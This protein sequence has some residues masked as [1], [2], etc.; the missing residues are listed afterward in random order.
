MKLSFIKKIDQEI[1]HYADDVQVI[2]SKFNRINMKNQ[3]G[4]KSIKLSLSF[5]KQLLGKFRLTRRF[6]RL[7]KMCVIPTTT[8]YV[9]FWQGGVYHL[10][11]DFFTLRHIMTMTGCRNPLHNAVANVD[12]SE[13]FFGEY[14]R[15]HPEG[16][17]I[18]RSL[19][20]GISWEKV[21]QISC[22]KIRHIHS[23]NWDPYERKIWVFTG[24]FEGQSHVICADRDFR[25]VEWIGNGSQ[26]Y[27][28]INPLFENDSIHW[29]M[30]S[31]LK[32]VHHVRLDRQTRQ[33]E[34]KQTFPG[35]VWYSKKLNDGYYL[36]A[37]AQEVGPSHQDECLHF[38][39]SKDLEQ[40]EDIAQF[41][42]DH[43]PKGLFKF[44]VIGFADGK[45]N[46][47]NFYLFFEAVKGYDGKSCLCQLED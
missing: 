22:D 29:I 21:Y 5:V 8:G 25:E 33:I 20:G 30:D 12:G 31:P 4:E 11:F 6:L 34:I 7:D 32:E 35:P 16:K 17:S 9:V 13:L 39:V 10:N 27:R 47:D 2:S 44:G 37:T 43:M 18:Y 26:H 28:A 15:P 46:R 1:I 45:Q 41:K 42:S 23:C 24:D 40:W 14:G 3:S 38:M 36:A 19:D